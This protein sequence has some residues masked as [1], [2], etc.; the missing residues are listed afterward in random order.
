[1]FMPMYLDK[2]LSIGHSSGIFLFFYTIQQMFLKVWV[3]DI[4]QRF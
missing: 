1:M 3:G 2:I 4:V